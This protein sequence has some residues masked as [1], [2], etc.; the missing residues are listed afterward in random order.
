MN[1]ISDDKYRAYLNYLYMHVA[2]LI[3][4][5]IPASFVLIQSRLLMDKA[6]I[7]NIVL[8][9]SCFS[10]KFVG[11]LLNVLK[12]NPEFTNYMTIAE[13]LS[14]QF[15][16]IGMYVFVFEML[17]VYY[18]VTVSTMREYQQS[19]ERAFIL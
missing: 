12:V 8:F 3:A 14:D 7:I 15:V 13:F 6:A 9:T 5:L 18:K 2:V 10:I 19:K 4:Y 1:D 16:V 11:A 17:I